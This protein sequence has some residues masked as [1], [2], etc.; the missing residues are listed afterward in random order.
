M[1]TLKTMQSLFAP[2][3][4]QILLLTIF[5]FAFGSETILPFEKTGTTSFQFLSVRPSARAA[6]LGGAFCTVADNSEAS[7]WNPAGLVKMHGTDISLSFIDYFFDVKMY[8]FSAAYTTLS[9]GTF[10]VFGMYSDIG[11]I[12]ET[13]VDA[14]HFNADNSFNPG[15]TGATF[16]PYQF[17]G[18]VSYALELTDNFAFG[19]NVK[20]VRENL[21]FANSSAIVF[22]GGMAFNTGYKSIQLGAS[23]KN[24]GQDVKFTD[25]KYPIPQ[26]MNIGASVNIIGEKNNNFFGES[27]EHKLQLSYDMIQPRDF[28]QEHA[29]GLEYTYKKM[30]AIRGGYK[31]NAD[32]E[33]LS[34]GLGLLYHGL[35]FDYAYSA[36]GDYLPSVH[37]I[38][39]GFEL[40]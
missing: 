27:D 1:K 33:S 24:F 15:L 5:L 39:L 6:A 31:L 14:L 3:R 30:I 20:Y 29:I 17:Y 22:D 8:S 26:T 25:K 35:R 37:R 10:G 40:R 38:T 32:Q 12:E 28:D 18:G 13:R 21:V 16:S 19:I 4:S 23:V 34:G 2:V 11:S 7:F 9:W 36:F